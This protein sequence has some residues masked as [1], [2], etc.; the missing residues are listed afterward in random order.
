M[1]YELL[2]WASLRRFARSCGAATLSTALRSSRDP[3][4]LQ[5][6]ISS[7]SYSSSICSADVYHQSTAVCKISMSHADPAISRFDR[8]RSS[9][10]DWWICR[11]WE[12]T[13]Q[14]RTPVDFRIYGHT[15]ASASSELTIFACPSLRQTIATTRW[16]FLL[17][18]HRDGPDGWVCSYNSES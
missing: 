10:V 12:V 13:V 16:Q 6:A 18:G 3:F 4:R 2:A 7:G 5:A 17:I 9:S 8:R 1:P 15:T 14:L 11:S